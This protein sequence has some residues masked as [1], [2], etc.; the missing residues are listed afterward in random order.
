MDDKKTK[1]S[2]DESVKI[3]YELFEKMLNN[4]KEIVK[5]FCR[6]VIIIFTILVLFMLAL[7][8]GYF[9]LWWWIMD[10]QEYINET[11]NERLDK[12]ETKVDSLE[13]KITNIEI[14][15]AKQM[16]I[17]EKIEKNV[18]ENKSVM[19]KTQNKIF[20]GIIAAIGSLVLAFIQQLIFN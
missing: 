7:L 19:S 15:N 20:W 5:M 12:L 11:V 8:I 13:N 3:P 17:L 6:T 14:S 4:Q 1:I 18:E 2:K 10:T 9:V 16:I